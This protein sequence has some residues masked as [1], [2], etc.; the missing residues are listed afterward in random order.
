[1]F[2]A[3]W[4]LDLA[5]VIVL[6]LFGG[7]RIK[8]VMR[9]LGSGIRAFK[10]G[11]LAENYGDKTSSYSRESNDPA[12]G[13]LFETMPHYAGSNARGVPVFTGDLLIPPPHA[14][15][16]HLIRLLTQCSVMLF[17]LLFVP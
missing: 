3:A 4:Q 16:T 13:H 10:H 8:D 9:S 6:F 5:A 7:T 17:A 12:A 1:M 2:D 11:W 15:R 14:V